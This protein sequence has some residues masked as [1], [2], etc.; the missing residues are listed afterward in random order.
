MGIPERG[1]GCKKNL[2]GVSFIIPRRGSA[3]FVLTWCV[4][5]MSDFPLDNEKVIPDTPHYR[6]EREDHWMKTLHTKAP[7]GLNIND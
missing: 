5:C 1:V 6:L 3:D 2:T 7:K 4:R